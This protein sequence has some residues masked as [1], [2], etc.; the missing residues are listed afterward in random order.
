[1]NACSAYILVVIHAVSQVIQLLSHVFIASLW[2]VFG[3]DY[4]VP[5]LELCL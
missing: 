2:A 4:A 3:I 5:M 1:M